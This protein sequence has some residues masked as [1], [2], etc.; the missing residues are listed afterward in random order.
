MALLRIVA[1]MRAEERGAVLKGEADVGCA[2][3][4]LPGA[5]DAGEPRGS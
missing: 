2:H 4:P 5:A 1:A 3:Q